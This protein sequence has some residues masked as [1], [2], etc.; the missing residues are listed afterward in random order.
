LKTQLDTKP[1]SMPA[2]KAPLV[3]DEFGQASM[4]PPSQAKLTGDWEVLPASKER[5]L[6][7]YADGTINARKAGDA[8]EFQ[9]EGTAIG[10]FLNVQTNG[11]KFEWSIDDGKSAPGDKSYGGPKGVQKGTVDTAPGPYFARNHYAMLSCGLAAGKH[12]LKIKVLEERDKT[13]SGNRLLIGHFLVAGP[14]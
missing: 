12:T 4:L 9:F 3:S 7:R 11:G 5:L 8:L 2:L 13:S 6:T 1:A 10:L 14:K